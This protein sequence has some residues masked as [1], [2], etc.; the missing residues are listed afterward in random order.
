MLGKIWIIVA[1]S[2]HDSRVYRQRIP[3]ADILDVRTG[4]GRRREGFV[5][6]WEGSSWDCRFGFSGP[7]PVLVVNAGAVSVLD[8]NCKCLLK[9]EGLN[10]PIEDVETVDRHRRGQVSDHDR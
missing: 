8:V 6:C 4:Y 10:K 7:V 3:W 9:W 1:H 5:D 2:N